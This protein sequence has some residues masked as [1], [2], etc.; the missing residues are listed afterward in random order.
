MFTRNN[1]T[2]EISNGDFLY[3]NT[4]WTAQSPHILDELIVQSVLNAVIAV[5]SN[6]H[7]NIWKFWNKFLR[8][9]VFW[10]FIQLNNAFTYYE[11]KQYKLLQITTGKF[12]TIF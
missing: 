1:L 4:Q 6:H 5:K 2:H 9:L 11:R 3:K 10:S 12:K 7:K 8:F